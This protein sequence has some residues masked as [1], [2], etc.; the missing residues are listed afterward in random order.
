MLHHFAFGKP[1]ERSGTERSSMGDERSFQY[2]HPVAARMRVF[3]IDHSGGITHEP[4]QDVRLRIDVE[5]FAEKSA[6]DSFVESFFPGQVPGV[7]GDQL[8]LIHGEPLSLFK[9]CIGTMN[10]RSHGVPASAGL[11]TR[12]RLKAGLHTNVGSWKGVT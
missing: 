12:S 4:D 5:L 8:A 9:A 7:N 2:I 1:D 10:L 6:P 3:W 11:T